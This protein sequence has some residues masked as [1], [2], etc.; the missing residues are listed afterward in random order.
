MYEDKTKERL[1]KLMDTKLDKV[2]KIN[3]IEVK[4]IKDLLD[5]IN[6]NS[7]YKNAKPSNFH[8][9]L[10]P[11]NIIY[12]S[13]NDKFVLIDWRESFGDNIE[14]GDVYYD[15][16][17]LYH[18]L[19]IN[20]DSILKGMYDYSTN[21]NTESAEVKFYAKS[22]LIHLM[23]FFED[24]CNEN[25]YDWYSVK[26]LGILHYLNICSLYDNF[27]S[28]KYGKFLFLYGKYLLTKHIK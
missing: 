19:L 26:L 21:S 5:K 6:W 14:V 10:Q 9:D 18:A 15:L 28:G 20:G 11:E 1:S 24:W 4:P 2:T 12:D 7:F 25:G 22:N 27:Q 17:K 8:G 16:S 13:E 3:G 23:D